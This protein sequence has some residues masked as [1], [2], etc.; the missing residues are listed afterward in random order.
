MGGL[1]GGRMGEEVKRSE[2]TTHKTL[3]PYIE[4]EVIGI[5]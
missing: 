4:N 5:F 2:T 3:M 1:E